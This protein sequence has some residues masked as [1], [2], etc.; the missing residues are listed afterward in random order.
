M[1]QRKSEESTPDQSPS[2]RENSDKLPLLSFLGQSRSSAESGGGFVGVLI[3]G[4]IALV[5]ALIAV[6]IAFGRSAENSP[7]IAATAQRQVNAPSTSYSSPTPTGPRWTPEPIITGVPQKQAPTLSQAPD[8]DSSNR[9]DGHDRRPSRPRG[10]AGNGLDPQ[11][12]D[13]EDDD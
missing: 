7:A 13:S 6:T 3:V 12:D 2:S 1:A 9:D 8:S 10:D 5:V 4:A 11:D